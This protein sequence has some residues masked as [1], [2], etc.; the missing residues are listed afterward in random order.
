MQKNVKGNGVK[1]KENRDESSLQFLWNSKFG[2]KQTSCK[3]EA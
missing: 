1:L 2:T 3:S